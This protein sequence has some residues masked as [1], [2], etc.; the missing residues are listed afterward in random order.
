MYHPPRTYCVVLR[1][2]TPNPGYTLYSLANNVSQRCRC[3]Y[4]H[5]F[6]IIQLDSDSPELENQLADSEY[7][8]SYREL[9][10]QPL[11]VTVPHKH[12]ST[13]RE[14]LAELY[15]NPCQDIRF[16][17][18]VIY[19]CCTRR[20]RKLRGLRAR[21]DRGDAIACAPFDLTA[22]SDDDGV[23]PLSHLEQYA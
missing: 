22:Y 13:L 17:A 18:N 23:H 8:S 16:L 21:V 15:A 12:V 6:G 5:P 9:A 3:W 19:G 10:Y 1:D 2:D 4:S 14:D 20:A 11:D 7:V